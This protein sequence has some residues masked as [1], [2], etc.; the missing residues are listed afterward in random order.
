MSHSELLQLRFNAEDAARSGIAQVG[1]KSDTIKPNNDI[2][3]GLFRAV[4][5]A[6]HLILM[7]FEHTNRI[8]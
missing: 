4:S 3:D 5:V 7:G 2:S 8:S 1:L 6:Y